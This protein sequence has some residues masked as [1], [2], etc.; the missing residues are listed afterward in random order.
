MGRH[1]GEISRVREHIP[2]EQGLRRR[3]LLEGDVLGISVREHIPLEQGLRRNVTLKTE[4]VRRGVREHIP[5]E[6]GLRRKVLRISGGI[7]G[8]SESIFH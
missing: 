6:Q 5:L 8:L 3:M 2:L 4:K 7:P 1:V